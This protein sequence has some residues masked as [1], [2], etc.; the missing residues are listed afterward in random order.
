[1]TTTPDVLRARREDYYLASWQHGELMLEPHCA[2]G[3]VLEEDFLCRQCVR[4]CDCTWILCEDAQTLSVVE[5]FIHGNPSFRHYRAALIH[6]E[7]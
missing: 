6:E 3:T 5:K 4:E 7:A 2:C 1:M